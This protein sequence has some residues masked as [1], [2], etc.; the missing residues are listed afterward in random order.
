QALSAQPQRSA[1]RRRRMEVVSHLKLI[2]HELMERHLGLTYSG[3][4]CFVV[5][6]DLG[7]VATVTPHLSESGKRGW[8]SVLV[9]LLDQTVCATLEYPDH[10]LMRKRPKGLEAPPPDSSVRERSLGVLAHPV[11]EVLQFREEVLPWPRNSDTVDVESA[12]AALLI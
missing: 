3:L 8:G 10:G 2:V 5:Q 1:L 6:V 12:H 11:K 7:D 9:H 4:V